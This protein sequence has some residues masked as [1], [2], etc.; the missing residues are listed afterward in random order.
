MSRAIGLGVAAGIGCG[1]INLLVHRSILFCSTRGTY[2]GRFE[3]FAIDVIGRMRPVDAVAGGVMAGL[4]EEP[5][6]RGVLVPAFGSPAIGVT[7]AA[8]VFGL[9][10]YL[11]RDYLGFLLW[12]MCEGVLFGTMFVVTD[13]IV[14]PAV[15]HGIFDTVGFIYFERMRDTKLKVCATASG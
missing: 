1:L 11:K 3:R 12:G 13:S 8:I 6:F 14:V 9:A 10:H 15:A 4:G 5:L 2:A 7:V